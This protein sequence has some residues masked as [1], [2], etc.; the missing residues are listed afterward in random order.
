VVGSG[1]SHIVVSSTSLFLGL[2]VSEFIARKFFMW[3]D[4]EEGCF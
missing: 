4:V 2:Y 1:V 3:E